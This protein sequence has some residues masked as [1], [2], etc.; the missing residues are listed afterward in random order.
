MI[1]CKDGRQLRTLHFVRRILG[2]RVLVA[3]ALE[4]MLYDELEQHI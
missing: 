2:S 4:L 1:T 3:R